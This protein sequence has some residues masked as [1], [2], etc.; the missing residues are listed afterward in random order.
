MRRGVAFGVVGC[1]ALV[2]AALVVGGCDSGEEGSPRPI[3][4]ACPAAVLDS[5]GL[6][7]GRCDVVEPVERWAEPRW[8]FDGGGGG[9]FDWEPLAGAE[10]E[11]YVSVGYPERNERA[12]VCLGPEGELRW[13]A[14]EQGNG[15]T[16]RL[17]LGP[18]GRLYD[19]KRVWE[20]QGCDR[21]RALRSGDGEVLWAAQPVPGVCIDSVLPV[22]EGRAFLRTSD[23]FVAL[24]AAGQVRW[25]V[26]RLS[27]GLGGLPLRA[28]A[29]G[30]TLYA[31]DYDDEGWVLRALRDG[32]ELWQVR[33]PAPG[34]APDALDQASDGALLLSGPG[35]L[36]AL[37]S[38][39]TRRWLW[40]SE[41]AGSGSLPAA[42]RAGVLEDAT[43][44]LYFVD[45]SGSA[46]LLRL[47]GVDGEPSAAYSPAWLE[48]ASVTDFLPFAQGRALLVGELAAGG[49][50]GGDGIPLGHL[51]QAAP[52]ELL[53]GG[54][55]LH[56]ELTLKTCGALETV[57]RG[58]KGELYASAAF[59][60]PGMTEPPL[61]AWDAAGRLLWAH[62]VVA[63][64]L[65]TSGGLVVYRA[66][67]MDRIVAVGSPL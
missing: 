27:P 20:A 47:G 52:D 24:D 30:Q 57:R 40:E 63:P 60:S 13:E 39:G 48:V 1:G 5:G 61:Y 23:R 32:A 2:F 67:E 56:S 18:E 8:T 29:D 62:P 43:G 6:D 26:D 38:D 10:G 3:R 50:Q 28:S 35:G 51:T 34:Q 66:A 22:A 16:P 11:V 59:E 33:A 7:T 65:L 42:A 17:A 36:E 19:F 37:N 25:E 64:W 21:L 41:A 55:T 54:G 44:G 14:R 4:C 46:G 15:E 31:G 58:A 53:A 12:V 45:R 49:Q 9:V